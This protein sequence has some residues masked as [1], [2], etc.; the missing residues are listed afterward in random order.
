M[1]DLKQIEDTLLERVNGG[2]APIDDPFTQAIVKLFEGMFDMEKVFKEA[3][4]DIY[5][6]FKTVID[7]TI[8]KLE[9]A[10]KQNFIDLVNRAIN[11]EFDNN[12]Q[13]LLDQVDAII[14][15]VK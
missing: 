6:V 12:V 2:S 10:D 5:L 15:K 9:P 4:N 11:G 14:A 1:T 13:G 8:Q 7:E 3:G